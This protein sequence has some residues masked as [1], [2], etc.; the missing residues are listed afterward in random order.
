[1][2]LI[3]GQQLASTAYAFTFCEL[4]AQAARAADAPRELP[5]RFS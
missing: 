4:L 3:L 2:K 1:M 5:Q